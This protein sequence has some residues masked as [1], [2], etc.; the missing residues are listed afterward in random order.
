MPK[1]DA[2]SL[3]LPARQL[4]SKFCF[5]RRHKLKVHYLEQFFLVDQVGFELIL[6]VQRNEINNLFSIAHQISVIDIKLHFLSKLELR[7]TLDGDDALLIMN[8]VHQ[9]NNVSILN[10][11]HLQDIELSSEERKVLSIG[12]KCNAYL[13]SIMDGYLLDHHHGLILADLDQLEDH[14]LLLV[15]A[16]LEEQSDRGLFRVLADPVIFHYLVLVRN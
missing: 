11:E 16:V 15:L 5:T 6:L 12:R 4:T 13:V 10:F 9:T 8:L 1:S 2:F 14:V 3:L 7:G